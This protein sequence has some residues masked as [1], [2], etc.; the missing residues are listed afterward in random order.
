MSAIG[1]QVQDRVEPLTDAEV[2]ML[3][4][5]ADRRTRLFWLA[6]EVQ[7][8]REAYRAFGIHIGA[9]LPKGDDRPQLERV[10]PKITGRSPYGQVP[11]LLGP[12]AGPSP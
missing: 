5:E 2:A 9:V 10:A 8:W 3:V 12:L 7:R 4:S 6:L 11:D 1:N